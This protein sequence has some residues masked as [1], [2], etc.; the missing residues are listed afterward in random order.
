MDQATGLREI[1]NH[2]NKPYQSVGVHSETKTQPIRTISITSGKGGVGKTSVV[3]NLA[4][5]FQIMGKR[6]LVID[7]DL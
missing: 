4:Q 1:C 6:V 3:A 2:S 7:A 5:A